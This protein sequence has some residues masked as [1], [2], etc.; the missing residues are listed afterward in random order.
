MHPIS[1]IETTKINGKVTELVSNLKNMH[2][3]PEFSLIFL[4]NVQI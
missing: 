4:I 2:S 1:D 3:S